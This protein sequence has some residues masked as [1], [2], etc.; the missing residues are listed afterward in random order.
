[1]ALKLHQNVR[2]AAVPF[3]FA[4]AIHPYFLYNYY[5]AFW[6]HFLHFIPSSIVE[7]WRPN[8][9]LSL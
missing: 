8:P 7:K 4:F 3:G 9:H 1:M 6:A 2:T 5:I